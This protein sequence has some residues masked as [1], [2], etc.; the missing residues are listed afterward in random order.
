M[1]LIDLIERNGGLKDDNGLWN[2]KSGRNVPL[3]GR[4]FQRITN[5]SVNDAEFLLDIVK[6]FKVIVE[7]VDPSLT[8]DQ[9]THMLTL[10]YPD[11]KGMGWHKDGYSTKNRKSNDGDF[12]APVYSLTLGNTCIFKYK[13]VGE[14]FVRSVELESGD[15]IV[16]GSDQREMYHQVS[17]V[18]CGTFKKKDG[19]DARINLT[20][21]TCSD[22][23]EEDDLDYQTENY[24][25]RLKEHWKNKK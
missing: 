17:E 12:G 14:K 16:F 22:L 9:V 21:R 7:E 4:K 2:F 13:L 18:K 20:F 1:A 6:K 10:W 5:Y 23:T 25:E 3:R 8:F 24:N 19:F 15:I 11:E